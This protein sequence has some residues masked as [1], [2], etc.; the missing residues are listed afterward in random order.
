MDCET[1]ERLCD[2]ET[3][4]SPA[5]HETNQETGECEINCVGPRRPFKIP[6]EYIR[7]DT[8]EETRKFDKMMSK[9]R[10]RNRISPTVLFLLPTLVFFSPIVSIFLGIV[11]I[12]LHIWAHK[13]N[14]SLTNR[15]H[16]YQSPLHIILSEFCA[17]CLDERMKMKITKIQDRKNSRF[18][19]YGIE[20]F[21]RIVK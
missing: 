10:T 1:G 12:S 4:E 9:S 14:K 19:K 15:D 11:E 17:S 7:Q 16:Y 13:K 6:T 18:I 21:R 5:K 20:Y 3:G 2:K 8:L